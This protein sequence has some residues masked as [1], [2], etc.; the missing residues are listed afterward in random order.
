MQILIL[1][2]GIGGQVASNLL[3]KE[4]GK[5]HD[6]VLVDRKTQYDFSPSFL[7]VTMGCVNGE[8]L[9]IDPAER[10]VKTSAG[11]LTYNYLIVALGAELAPEAIPGF[12]ECAHHVY[13]LE[14]AMK[15][16][17]ELKHF[18]GGNVVVGVS[19]LPFRCPAAPYEA[20]L[21]MDY[22]FKS[23]EIRQKVDFQFF[24]PESLPMGVAPPK[25]GNMVK[26]MLEDR[27]ISYHPN[28]KLASVD[29]KKGEIAFEGGRIMNFDL[30]FAVPPHRPPRAVKESKLADGTG[31]IPVDKKS[32]RTN[33]DDV[34]AVGDVT[35]IEL[36]N[37]KRLPMAG[38]FA[39]DQTEIVA[40]NIISE[41]KDEG[42]RKECEGDGAC[43]IET[44]FGKAAMAKGNFYTEPD[45]EVNVRWPKVSRIWHWY[46]IL[47]EKYWLWRYF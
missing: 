12:S 43:F 3:G 32:L 9:K 20:A 39:H 37:G 4:L 30:I 47:F 31:W 13:T 23:N 36:A 8:V 42:K 11:D 16:G 28:I 22:H 40:H 24:T 10:T 18:S 26:G 46:K 19:S 33:Y 17:E 6:I 45:P 35:Y 15:L 29:S 34:Y 27:D 1:G 14:A 2:G 5:K 38:V 44:G 7:W 41:I 25:I 21:L